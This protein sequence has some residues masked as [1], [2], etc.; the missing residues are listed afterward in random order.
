MES[1]LIEIIDSFIARLH[2]W[3]R[4]ATEFFKMTRPERIHSV[5]SSGCHDAR[6]AYNRAVPLIERIVYTIK[7]LF[8]WI[9]K[10]LT[11]KTQISEEFHISLDTLNGPHVNRLELALS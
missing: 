9:E 3:K 10:E 5:C 4:K 6:H 1:S 8:H 7:T 11:L 2:F